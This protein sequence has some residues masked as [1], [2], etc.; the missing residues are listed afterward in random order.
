MHKR[1]SSFNS[2][3]W[4]LAAVFLFILLLFAAI[5]MYIFIASTDEYSAEL[6]QKLN[7][8][9]AEHTVQEV[10]PFIDYISDPFRSTMI[11]SFQYMRS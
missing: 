9:L 5:S 10:A 4:R 8:D 1:S 7:A 2:L 3:I 11:Q 6:S